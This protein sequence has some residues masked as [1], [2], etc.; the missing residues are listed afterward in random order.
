[1]SLIWILMNTSVLETCSDQTQLRP[2]MYLEDNFLKRN[3]EA[4][5]FA[6]KRQFR[7]VDDTEESSIYDY[8]NTTLFYHNMYN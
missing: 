1:M 8:N 2:K 4:Q 7:F 6:H 5:L 3:Y